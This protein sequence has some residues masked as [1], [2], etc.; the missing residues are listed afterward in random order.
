MSISGISYETDPKKKG[1]EWKRIKKLASESQPG[2]G[3]GGYLT[4]MHLCLI[5]DRKYS[6]EQAYT[7]SSL[8]PLLKQ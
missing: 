3:V 4:W 1:A 7:A 8:K 2:I 5:Q 6:K